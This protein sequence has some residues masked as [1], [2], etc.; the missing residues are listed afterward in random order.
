MGTSYRNIQAILSRWFGYN[1]AFPTDTGIR[2]NEPLFWKASG[3]SRGDA[4]AFHLDHLEEEEIKMS[5]ETP[6]K[7]FFEYGDLVRVNPSECEDKN[8]A[9]KIGRVINII[10][11]DGW[12]ELSDPYCYNIENCEGS[13][14]FNELE[15]L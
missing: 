13:F 12:R 11:L 7:P 1:Q 4:S 9:S 8:Q 15:M 10:L 5:I 6:T 14:I 2:N 3:A